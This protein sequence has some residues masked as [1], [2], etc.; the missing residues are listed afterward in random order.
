MNMLVDRGEHVSSLEVMSAA[1]AVGRRCYQSLSLSLSVILP[2][3]TI[4]LVDARLADGAGVLLRRD[5]AKIILMHLGLTSLAE[6]EKVAFEDSL[7]T[8]LKVRVVDT[9]RRPDSLRPSC[10]GS[11]S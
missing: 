9:N 2:V 11:P 3:P 5:Q 8:W 1:A 10:H 7:D 4:S 6:L